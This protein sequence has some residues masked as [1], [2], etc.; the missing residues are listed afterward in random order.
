MGKT[1]IT[2]AIARSLKKSGIDVGVMKP[3]ATGTAMEQGY[4]S[5]DAELLRRAINAQDGEET[6]NPVFLPLPMSP[7]DASKILNVE[8]DVEKVFERFRN[9]SRSH[10]MVLVEGIGGIMTP[11]KRDFFVADMIKRLGLE[12]IIV[13]RSTLGTLNHTL[14]TV[15]A[16]KTWQIPIAGIV[17]NSV[18]EKGGPEEKNAAS[19]LHEI[20]GLAVLG[21]IPFVKDCGDLDVM[22]EVVEQNIDLGRLIS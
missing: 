18:G 8:S 19:T 16:C 20:T 21:V 11:I 10:Q 4:K 14:L 1:T 15:Q 6:V 13:T 3:V 5:E 17:V 22:A 12:T 2:A 9:L 7:Y